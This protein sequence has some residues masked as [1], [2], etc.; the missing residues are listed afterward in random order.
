[1]TERFPYDLD[2]DDILAQR[3]DTG[4]RGHR[5]HAGEVEDDDEFSGEIDTLA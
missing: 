2:D 3:R 1:M 5:E 4:P